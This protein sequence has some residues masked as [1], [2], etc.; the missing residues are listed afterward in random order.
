MIDTNFVHQGRFSMRTNRSC[1]LA[2]MTVALT[3]VPQFADAGPCSSDI[4]ELE[5]TVHLPGV[6][7][8]D[9][10]GRQ[11]ISAPPELARQADE[12][13]QSQFSATMARAK[14]L[15]M[16]G[17]RVGCTGALNAARG[18]YVLVDRD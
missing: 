13:L 7:P 4:A 3:M 8:L 12:H 18:I 15:D 5:T 16:Y 11:S 10:S 17:D 2:V 14:R 9:E 1:F 6:E